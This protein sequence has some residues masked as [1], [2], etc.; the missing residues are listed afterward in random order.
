M[1]CFRVYVINEESCSNLHI[2][3]I[4][5]L[6]AANKCILVNAVAG[7]YKPRAACFGVGGGEGGGEMKGENVGPE[8]YFAGKF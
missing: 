2:M 3:E 7:Q 6:Q 4:P 5:G 8:A 1:G